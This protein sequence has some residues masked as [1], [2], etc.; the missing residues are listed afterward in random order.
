M[1]PPSE[2]ISCTAKE[3]SHEMIHVARYLFLIVAATAN[4]SLAAFL[5]AA[6]AAA[7]QATAVRIGEHTATTRFVVELTARTKFDIFVLAD[8][9]RV[10]IDLPE[11][12]WK[13][14]NARQGKSVGVID[15]YRYGLF[16]PGTSRIVLDLSGPATVDRAFY[17]AP[18]GSVRQYRLV[19]DLKATNR[20]LFLAEVARGRQSRMARNGKRAAVPVQPRPANAL[21]VIAIDPGHGG[22]DPGTSGVVDKLEKEITL[23]VGLELKRRLER[24]GRFQV[25]MTRSRDVF[26]PLR[27]RVEIARQANADLLLSIH[28][29]SLK[30]ASVRGATVYTLSEKA[31]DREAASL[32]ARENKSD[33]I[34]GIDLDGES[35]DVATILIDLAQ[36]ETMNFSAEMAALLLPK[37]SKQIVL[38]SNSHRFA[39]FIVLK[40]PDVPSV[41]IEMGYLSNRRD[42]QLLSSV[43]GHRGIAEALYAAIA[44][45]FA[46]H[47]T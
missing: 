36:R 37:L 43:A 11:I 45:Y 24:D 47:R 3:L 16:R 46:D 26:V 40:A 1:E 34:A 32:A 25:V 20:S 6:A 30:N 18:R 21:K 15:L 7:P 13:I 44:L 29:D 38:R 12:D 2:F 35:D 19:I 4:L 31:S 14:N 5:P 27:R 41:L 10:V 17:M 9:Y 8:P 39:G 42:A 23:A 22:I 28:V 33:I